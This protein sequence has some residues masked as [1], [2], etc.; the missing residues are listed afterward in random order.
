MNMNESAR[1][2][3]AEYVMRKK[4]GS[5]NVEGMQIVAPGIF[6]AVSAN[7]NERFENFINKGKMPISEARQLLEKRKTTVNPATVSALFIYVLA[8]NRVREIVMEAMAQ[9][10]E[11]AFA[12]CVF[13]IKLGLLVT[14]GAI[15]EAN[16]LE[17]PTGLHVSDELIADFLTIKKLF[18]Q[19]SS[20]ASVINWQINQFRDPNTSE[21][22]IDQSFETPEFVIAGAQLFKGLYEKVYPKVKAMVEV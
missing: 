8:G 18:Q 1:N 12:A 22:W 9:E 21:K 13:D 11:K 5:S 7:L 6:R 16:K 17:V 20:G 3:F 19:E 4:L 15:E 10:T 14:A 2:R